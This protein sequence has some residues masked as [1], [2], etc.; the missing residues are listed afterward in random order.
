MTDDVP[1]AQ[2]DELL[3]V[4]ELDSRIRRIQHQLD[5]LP[6]QQR[7][8]E[9]AAQDRELADQQGAL[10]V[11]LDRAE[12][13]SR[14]LEGEIDLLR[15]RRDAEQARM[16]GGEIS[17]PRELQSLRAELESTE[18][19][20]AEHEEQL[21]EVMERVETLEGGVADLGSQR[22]SITSELEKLGADRDRAAGELLAERAELEVERDRHRGQLPESL[23]ARY[24]DAAARFS[25][26]ALGKLAGGMCTACRIELPMVDVNELLAGPSL[27]TCPNCR[28]L[29]VTTA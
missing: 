23:L 8:E 29:L 14:R 17:N 7:Y 15:Q 3:T 2:L 16:Y 11:D 21:L 27:A 22:A 4:Q 18:R 19:R 25:G 12:A 28:R 1:A 10:R 26:V 6:E 20:I 24:D 13:D 5:H 9:V